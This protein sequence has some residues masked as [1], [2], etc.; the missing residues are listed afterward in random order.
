MVAGR[1][2]R[3]AF[4]LGS[5]VLCVGIIA[6][7]ISVHLPVSLFC[8]WL[9]MGNVTNWHGCRTIRLLRLL[10]YRLGNPCSTDQMTCSTNGVDR[11]SGDVIN[12]VLVT[13]PGVN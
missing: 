9:I 5:S 12:W 10:V 11:D 6:S 1:V 4:F 8:M 7:Y 3:W 13:T 2:G